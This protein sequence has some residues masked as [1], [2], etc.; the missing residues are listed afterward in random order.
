MN[1]TTDP[2]TNSPN[3]TAFDQASRIAAGSYVRVA[4]SLK[5]YAHAQ[6]DASVLVFDDAT[7]DQIDFDLHGSDEEVSERLLRRF[8]AIGHNGPRSLGRP[9]I[10]VSPRE[11]TLL[12]R[13]WEW[14]AEQ[15]GGASAA[16]RKLVESAMRTGILESQNLRKLQDRTYR[17]MSAMA[18]N[19][20]SF[21]D[22][23]RALFANNMIRFQELIANWPTDVRNHVMQ[24]S[25]GSP[26]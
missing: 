21:E 7:G 1:I 6:P 22:A 8:P 12:P 10:G 3:C 11:V 4:L 19:Y 26:A 24:L 18:G 16:L 13:H 17:F 15:P 2:S 25:T 23:S 14:L 9:K 5:E 20:P